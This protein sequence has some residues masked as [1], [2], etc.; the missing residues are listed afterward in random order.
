MILKINPSI[1]K[2]SL[3]IQGLCFKPFYGHPDGCPN[4]GKTNRGCPPGLPL[5]NKVLDFDKEVYLIYTEFAVGEY[6]EKI[7][8]LHPQWKDHQRMWYNPRYWQP[9]ARKKHRKDVAEALKKYSL[10][11]IIGSPEGY[12]VNLSSLMKDTVNITLN[13][14]WPPEHIIQDDEYKKNKTYRISLG[15]FAAKK[16]L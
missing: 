4:I 13:W 16:S 11:T 6:A 9:T 3:K 15:G 14:K 8:R 7:R 1:I 2:Y 10:D 5:I 12:G